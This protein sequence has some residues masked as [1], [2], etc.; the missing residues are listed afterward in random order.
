MERKLY[1]NKE[2]R[3]LCGVCAGVADYFG[4]DVTIVRLIWVA[5]TLCYSI[6]FWVYIIAA[7]LMP[8]KP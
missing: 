5:M 1:R 2:N 7:V 3:F 8:D 6:G 4:I